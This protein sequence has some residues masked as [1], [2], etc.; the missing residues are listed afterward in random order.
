[1]NKTIIL[2]NGPPGSGKDTAGI[3]LRDE[4][5]FHLEKFA[6][7]IRTAVCG[8]FGIEDEEI[9]RL[10]NTPMLGGYTLRE[11]MIGFSEDYV[12]RYGGAS[13]FGDL[14]VER[15]KRVEN[16]NVVVTDCGFQVEVGRIVEHFGLENVHLIRL[17]REGH[18]FKGDSR[19]YV[20]LPGKPHFAIYN[21]RSVTDFQDRVMST[22]ID[23]KTFPNYGIY[24]LAA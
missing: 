16:E 6:S 4:F 20:D 15:L 7:P 8:L 23:I 21:D 22:L 13:V 11:W 3:Y 12:K 14:L 17:Y 10:K 2:V 9:E 18:T 1:M 5:G 19:S 24:G